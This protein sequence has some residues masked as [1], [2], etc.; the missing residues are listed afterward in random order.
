MNRTARCIRMLMI[1]KSRESV[2][3][4][5]LSELLDTNPRNIREYKKELEEAGF[6]IETIRGA[7][8][9]YKLAHSAALPIPV[10]D[11]ESMDILR[12]IRDSLI[13]SPNLPYSKQGSELIDHILAANPGADLEMPIYFTPSRERDF[14]KQGAEELRMIRDAIVS[15]RQ[16]RIV[17]HSK[18]S[19]KPIARTVDPYD[20]VCADGEWYFCG[21]DSYRQA[22]RTFS[23]SEKRLLSL[24]MLESTF[25]KDPKYQL[26]DYIGTSSLTREDTEFYLVEVRKE[27]SRFFEEIKWGSNFNTVGEQ[28][29][30]WIT[31]SFYSDDPVYIQRTIFRLGANVRLLS[32]RKRVREF[33]RRLENILAVYREEDED[34]DSFE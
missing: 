28:N 29:R 30:G 6:E 34:D 25:T 31:Y 21:Y 9:G 2:C 4:A 32:P 13:A 3:T 33:T 20:V 14:P 23:V 5:E 7:G 27:Q 22:I 10:F 18:N 24:E 8:G 1:L 12:T 15:N 11:A 16:L 26:K 17:Y 19:N